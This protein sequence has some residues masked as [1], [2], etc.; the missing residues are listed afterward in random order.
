M[1]ARPPVNAAAA[2][3]APV[4][5]IMTVDVPSGKVR[6]R[7]FDCRTAAKNHAGSSVSWMPLTGLLLAAYGGGFAIFGIFAMV[8]KSPWVPLSPN[9]PT[10]RATSA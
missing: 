10:P 2:T 7:G 6:K 3:D 5:T 9:Y 8:I 4:A 1:P